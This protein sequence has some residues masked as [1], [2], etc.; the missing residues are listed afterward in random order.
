MNRICQSIRKNPPGASSTAV[1]PGDASFALKGLAVSLMLAFASNA[2]ALPTGGVVSA[3][4]ADISGGAGTL[5][6]NQ[7]T[8]NA[9]VNWQSFNI[10][11]T[12][13]VRFV[14]PNSSAVALNRVIGPDPSSILGSLTANGRVFLVN[15]NGIL[16]GRGASVNVG[17]LVASTRNITDSDFMSGQYKFTGSGNGAVLNQ[18]TINA[19]GG[20]VALLG[21]NISNEG[22]IVARLGTVALAAGNAFTLDVAGDGLLNVAVNQG[23]MDALV[24]NGGLIRA[25]GGQVLLTAQS[26]GNLLQSAV[27]NTGIIQAQ[28]I[29]N[30]NGSIRLLGD[31]QAG[32]VSVGGILDVSGTATGQT[33]G[34]VTVTGHHVGLFDGQINASGD[35][36]GGTVLIGGDF[37]G[38]A[39]T[40][41][42]ASAT[43]MSA[44]SVINADAI[45]NGNGGTVVLWGNDSTRAKGTITARGGALGGDGGLIETS[46]HFLDVSGITVNAS[47][48]NGDRGLWL[49]DP[50]N[51]IIGAGTTNATQIGNVFTPDSG[52]NAATVDAGALRGA[53]ETAGG[54]DI[55]I[56][57]INNGAPG[58]ANGDITVAA[59]LTWTPVGSATLTLNAAGDVNINADISA[60]RGNLVVC[61]GRDINVNA[62][63]TTVNGSVLLSAGRDVNIVRNALNPTAGITTTDGNIAM[64]AGR[65]VLLSNQFNGAALV[66]LTT[67]ST[68]AGQDLAN[69]GVTRGLTLKAG[70]AGN[71][72]GVAGGTVAITAGTI[73]TVT[74]P[75]GISPINIFYNP[76]SYTTPTDYSGFFAT[77]NGAPLTQ[78]MLVY[79]DGASK[80]FDGTTTA[81][82]TGLKGNPAG[83]TLVGPG[84]ASFD[85]PTSGTGKTVTFSGFSLAQG[86]ITPGGGATNF[87]LPAS[88]CG[89]VVGRT[90]ADITGG[91]G[92]VQ[93][94]P[95]IPLFTFPMLASLDLNVLGGITMP[96]IQ[97]AAAPIEVIP[98]PKSVVETPVEVKPKE[99]PVYVPP[100]RPRKADR[101]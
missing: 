87:A 19:D 74:G 58:S 36:G 18:G 20:Y 29:E 89:P 21:A 77:G 52:V 38:K 30:R 17:G 78:F 34:N 54:T 61:C 94:T 31:M 45:T 42:N 46:A 16:F 7:T 51:V 5:T 10:G 39:L 50:A 9:V 47:A 97:V 3:G 23:A 93:T 80:A 37:Q 15:P 14:Q 2:W 60:N 82:F 84:V 85:T 40:V 70:N 11:Q 101:E 12:E 6:V 26:A 65:D 64:C 56:T 95:V 91:T 8:Q 32:T 83:V 63:V 67:G 27:N 59:A 33:G 71:G 86:P 75:A 73:V 49:L 92:T 4:S 62:L 25:D 44:D 90:T 79:P 96:P 24:Q 28:T 57:T 53:L 69:L 22:V 55:T 88:C 68:T 48:A 99:K 100:K 81:N 72:P 98:Q 43:Y 66:T 13:A 35:A 1:L 41:Q 76:T